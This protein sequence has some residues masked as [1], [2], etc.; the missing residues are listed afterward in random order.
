[1]SRKHRHKSSVKVENPGPAQR[2]HGVKGFR[3][4]DLVLMA[5]PQ[6]RKRRM[7]RDAG[8]IISEV[9]AL[10]LDNAKKRYIDV[11]QAC[12]I[13]YAREDKEYTDKRV[14]QA[15]IALEN[16]ESVEGN[17]SLEDAL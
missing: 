10:S 7:L 3:G 6:C 16:K 12:L 8:H 5:C 15:E 17:A 4:P 2:M 14:R 11:C 1:V 9:K 13:K